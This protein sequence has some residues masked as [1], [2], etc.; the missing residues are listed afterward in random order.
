MH[1]VSKDQFR[2]GM[3][4][5]AGAVT[6]IATQGDAG[7]GGL[8]ATAV[9]S[10]SDEPPTLLTCINNNN[11]LVEIIKINDFFS[12]NLLSSAME[13][14]S[15]RFAGFDK[16][17]MEERFELGSWD[18]DKT[19]SPVLEGSLATFCCKVKEMIISGTH[20][21]IFGEIHE[22]YISEGQTPLLYFDRNYTSVSSKQ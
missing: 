19:T 16:V 14:I 21:V 13:A 3:K 8:T 6:I 22:V 7:K 18:F 15:N 1:T 20:T 11:E 5:L 4:L 17:P 9:C 12:V 2:D 10:V